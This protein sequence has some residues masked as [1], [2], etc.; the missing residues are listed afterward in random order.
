MRGGVLALVDG[1]P[2][3][4]WIAGSATG[5]STFRVSWPTPRTVRGVALRLSDTAPAVPARSVVVSGGGHSR[6]VTLDEQG[7]G[8]F[9]PLRARHLTIQVDSAAVGYS[10]DGET[11]TPLPLGVGDL[12][13]FGPQ[14]QN[15]VDAAGAPLRGGCG[16]GPTVQLG[17]LMV[18]TRFSAVLGGSAN[19]VSLKPC[20]REVTLPAGTV[21][22]VAHANALLAVDHIGLQS[23]PTG[24]PPVPLATGQWGDRRRT[25]TVPHAPDRRL[26]VVSQNYNAGWRATL[27]GRSLTPQEV[28]GWRQGWWLPAGGGTVVL[29]FTPQP[30]YVAG[31][32][33]GALSA[34]LVLLLVLLRPGRRLRAPTVPR[35]RVPLLVGVLLMAGV[36]GLLAGWWGAAAAVVVTVIRNL[37][38]VAT[39][40]WMVGPL[41]LLVGG[42]ITALARVDQ[43]LTNSE[44]VQVLLVAALAAVVPVSPRPSPRPPR[45]PDP[46]PTVLRRRKGLSIT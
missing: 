32:A 23:S 3:T 44:V 36:G 16:S 20:R 28:D 35:G 2:A 29:T 34:L 15:L 30:R 37:P 31:L 13:V 26:L 17:D 8:R 24:K 22:V 4:A 21:H 40:T 11:R 27:D 43:G 46:N 19:E 41:A 14:D 5:P 10:L 7:V 39:N 18:R 1:D 25:I 45:P 33:L 42:A 12:T 9:R 6:R 38:R